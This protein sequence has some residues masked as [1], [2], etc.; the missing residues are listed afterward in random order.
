MAPRGVPT[1]PAHAEGACAPAPRWRHA[2]AGHVPRSLRPARGIPGQFGSPHLAPEPAPPGAA[3]ACCGE[4]ASIARSAGETSDADAPV[5][6][7]PNA[8]NVPPWAR[9]PHGGDDEEED[10]AEDERVDRLFGPVE[11]TDLPDEW[12]RALES[13]TLPLMAWERSS[14]VAPPRA[15]LRSSVPL[16][17]GIGGVSPG[18]TIRE[19]IVSSSVIESLAVCAGESLADW[20]VIVGEGSLVPNCAW[21]ITGSWET[22]FRY[23]VVEFEWVG[24]DAGY[25]GWNVLTEI[26]GTTTISYDP[27]EGAGIECRLVLLTNPGRTGLTRVGVANVPVSISAGLDG[28]PALIRVQT[29]VTWEV[30]ARTRRESE[31]PGFIVGFS[32][33]ADTCWNFA[34]AYPMGVATGFHDLA[35]GSELLQTLDAEY[36]EPA[37]GLRYGVDRLATS[38]IWDAARAWLAERCETEPTVPEDT[39]DDIP[40]VEEA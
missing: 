18:S 11:H 6:G 20:G 3:D 29:R 40:E 23:R 12:N 32:Y 19:T 9:A 24:S 36:S 5:P 39:D 16:G 38:G 15:R 31:R 27:G 2:Y 35:G 4:C 14:K 1:S 34:A 26:R 13:G 21:M 30:I 33:D 37:Q 17:E 25:C 22:G 8:G 7:S 10:I 28:L